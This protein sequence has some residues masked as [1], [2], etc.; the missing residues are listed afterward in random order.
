MLD[1]TSATSNAVAG[2]D[3]VEIVDQATLEQA[4]KQETAKLTGEEQPTSE[5]P[6]ALE[7]TPKTE[8]VKPD[9]VEDYRERYINMRKDYERIIKEKKA[10]E[11]AK[12]NEEFKTKFQDLDYDQ[13]LALIADELQQTKAKYSEF[14]NKIASTL[15]QQVVQEDQALVDSFLTSDPE[16]SN[17]PELHTIFKMYANSDQLVDPSITGGKEIPWNQVKLDDIKKVVIQ[18]ILDRVGARKV[19][20]KERPLI[21]SSPKVED[22]LT[23]EAIEKMTPHEYEQNRTK[24]YKKYGIRT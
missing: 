4:I 22:D 9:P 14:E 24:I 15:Q 3:P 8:D 16:L 17:L 18:P 11:E 10:L 1:D 23:E 13:R 7:D 21:G 20:V 5:Q 6:K 2:Q 12:S 19:T